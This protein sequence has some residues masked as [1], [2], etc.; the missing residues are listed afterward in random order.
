MDPSTKISFTLKIFRE[1]PVEFARD[2]RTPYLHRFLYKDHMPQFI[3]QAF[4]MCVLYAHKTDENR[5]LMLRVLHDNVT[6]LLSSSKAT[7]LTPY[8][9]LARVHA[10]IF[11][12][13]IRM[14]DGDITLGQQANN[15]FNLL[16]AWIDDLRKLR[17]NLTD[18]V[19]L[20]EAT[21]RNNPPQSWEVRVNIPPYC[22]HY[23]TPTRKRW[24]FA[25]SLRR[26]VMLGYAL[27]SISELLRGLV[28]KPGEVRR[29]AIC[30]WQDTLSNIDLHSTFG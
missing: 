23:L 12:Q 13:I 8:E 21:L 30:R 10:L 17:D 2:N 3:T 25:E 4:C 16:E 24:V 6:S 9:K 29:R 14:F 19:G 15:D 11:Y 18:C 22:F 1:L 28:N 7:S 26:T 20:D 27:K 5:G